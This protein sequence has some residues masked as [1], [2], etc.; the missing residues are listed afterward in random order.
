MEGGARN[1]GACERGRRVDS[2]GESSKGTYLVGKRYETWRVA[3]F[4]SC[5]SHWFRH[6]HPERDESHPLFLPAPAFGTP[7]AIYHVPFVIC[8]V[9]RSTLRSQLDGGRFIFP[10]QQSCIRQL[11]VH[12]QL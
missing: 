8:P 3:L 11:E 9:L 5:P 2:V 7:L 4:C 6:F 1:G 12:R 10:V